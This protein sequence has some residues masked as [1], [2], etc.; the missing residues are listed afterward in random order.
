MATS[1]TKE[2]TITVLK[3]TADPSLITINDDHTFTLTPGAYTADVQIHPPRGFT[4]TRLI[5]APGKNP[6]IVEQSRTAR[7]LGDIKA[8]TD[9]IYLLQFLDGREW[10]PIQTLP[11]DEYT[12]TLTKQ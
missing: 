9:D 11:S 12:I 8:T 6:E 7:L 10:K 2:Q 4:N 5:K 3:Q 1:K